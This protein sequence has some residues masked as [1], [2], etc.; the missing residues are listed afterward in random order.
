MLMKSKTLL[1]I[2]A[3]LFHSFIQARNYDI[4]KLGIEDGLSNNYVVS[5]TQDRQGFMWF[6][7]ELGLNRFDGK[8]IKIYKKNS[9]KSQKSISGNELNKVYA[10]KYDDIIWIATQREGLNLF[11]CKTGMFTHFR[12]SRDNPSG[13]ITNDITDVINSKDGNIWLSTYHFGIDYYDKKSKTF[14]HFNQNTIPGLVSNNVWSVNEDSRGYLYIGHVK[15]GLSVISLNDM[16]VKN[17]RHDPHNENSLPG[18]EVKA[19][20]VD[21]NDNVWIGTNNGLALFNTEREIFTIFRHDPANRKSLVADYVYSINQLNDGRLYVGTD[22]GGVSILDIRQSMFVDPNNVSLHNI[23]YSDDNRGF[24]HPT[25]HSVYQDSFNNI[26][27][28]TYGGGVN[29]I[30]HDPPFFNTWSYSPIPTIDNRLSNP[31]AWGLCTDKDDR[32][33]VGTDGGGINVYENGKRI[34]LINKNNGILKDNTFLAAIKDTENNLWFGTYR[35]GIYRYDDEKKALNRFD[36]KDFILDI[37]CFYE[38]DEKNMWIGVSNGLYRYDMKSRQGELYSTANSDLP[39][40]FIR[41]ITKDNNGNLWIGFFGEGLCILDKNMKIVNRLKTNQG[42]L[43]NTINY[44][45][46]DDAGQIWAA[47]GEGLVLFKEPRNTEDFVI[48]NE[49]DGLEN[50]HIRA[51]A[52]DKKGNIW[53]SCIGGISRYMNEENRFYNYD[54]SNRVPLGDFM[55]GSVTKDSKGNIYFGSQNGVCYFSPES[56][57]TYIELPPTTVT[58]FKI[59]NNQLEMSDNQTDLLSYSNI[60]LD[61]SENTFNVSFSILDY[62]LNQLVEYSYMLKGLDDIWYNTQGDNS[63]TF[64][65]IPPGKYRLLIK[66]RVK[67]QEWSDD[68]TSLDIKINPPVWFSWW[69]KTIYIIIVVLITLFIL[70]FYKRKLELENTLTLEKRNHL[71]EQE[72]NNERLRFFTNITHE[73][74]TPLT[75]ILG[76]LEDLESDPNLPEKYS[77]KIS[78]IHRS[79][80]RLLNLINQILEFRR[81]ETQNKKLSVYKSDISQLVHEV[82]LKY[83]ELNINKNIKFD[84]FIE[85]QNTDIYFDPD[86]VTTILENLLSNAFKYTQKGNIILTLREVKEVNVKYTEIEVRDTGRGIAPESLTKIFDRYF[87]GEKEQQISGTG[88]GLA[89]VKNLVS[90]HQGQIFVESK[91]GVGTSFRFRIVSDNSYPDA[92]HIDK[93]AK[94]LNEEN[95]KQEKLYASDNKQIILVVE[96]NQDI[97]EYIYDSLSEQYKVYTAENGKAGIKE[98]FEHIPDIIVSDIMMPEMDGFELS[99]IIKEDVRTSHIPI[100]LLTAKDSIQDKTEGYTIGVD[101][102]ITK[103]FSASLLQSRIINLLDNRKK[104]AEIINRNATNKNTIITDSL[105]RIDN[106]FIEKITGII[107]ENLDSDKIDVAF[108]AEKMNMSHSTLYRKIKAL[109]GISVNEFIRKVRIKNAEKL[110]LT[111]KYTISEISYMVGINSITYFRQCFKEEY[112]MAPSEYIKKIMNN[113]SD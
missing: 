93:E 18:N 102:Y 25:I 36:I 10:D 42:L 23:T 31:I 3:T 5:I 103:P 70:H 111:G 45:L 97:L 88:I 20:Y 57:P 22:R 60:K 110:L 82:G 69:A 113:N 86:I 49:K 56:V 91:Q 105:N 109:S 39:D 53:M 40:N 7:T 108:I 28:A 32:V 35:G 68:F 98:A 58:G 34:E 72:L 85:T 64:R 17:Y 106:E 65:N 21:N 92:L 76:P 6:A 52:Q 14:K 41:A 26:W 46:K 30:S 8:K 62:S 87:Q 11:D 48:Y 90:V 59:Y 84:I 75:L 2:I 101:S 38:D 83:K 15:A 89:L 104:L 99:K 16:T 29:F 74:R 43:S 73:L 1:I 77:S 19:I 55:G 71:Q 61:Y 63:V 33:W 67:N 44:L 54:H 94:D 80:T 78:V 27:F 47:T 13:L 24:S 37:R 12:A 112:G 81:T 79:T 107:K 51:I 4:K 95:I 9:E 100:I 50:T 66:S 96:D